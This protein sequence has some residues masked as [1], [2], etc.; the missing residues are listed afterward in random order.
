MTRSQGAGPSRRKA[1]GEGAGPSRQMTWAQLCG[2]PMTRSQGAGPSRR[3]AE[4]EGAG[5]SRQM[6]W[7]QLCGRPMTRAQ[8]AGT[9]RQM[10]WAQL[11]G[12]PVAGRRTFAA[13][14]EGKGAGPSRQM[15]WARGQGRGGGSAGVRARGS[16]RGGS[17]AGV[18][19]RGLMHA[20]G[21]CSSTQKPF[22][23]TARYGSPTAWA[24]RTLRGGMGIWSA[25]PGSVEAVSLSKSVPGRSAQS[26]GVHE[27]ATDIH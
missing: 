1:E 10:T 23:T 20:L 6:T 13:E 11:C 26:W 25:C 16:G 5:P 14:A 21:T 2:R 22:N 7:A 4:G 18:A 19:A 27:K 12:R 9:S 15:T 17:S 3:K 8:G 24:S